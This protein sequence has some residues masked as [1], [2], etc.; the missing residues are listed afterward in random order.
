MAEAKLLDQMLERFLASPEEEQKRLAQEVAEASKSLIWVPNPGPQTEAYNCEADELLYGGEPS[1]GKSDLGIGLSLTEH[2]RSLVLRRTNAEAVKL[3]D[4]YEEIIGHTVGRNEQKGWKLPGRSIDIGGCQLEKDKQKRKGI[5]HDLKFFDELTDFTKTQYLFI[6]T[7]NRSTNPNQR[8]R[9]VATTNAPTNT[10][11]VWVIERWAAWLDPKHANPAKDGELRWYLTM[12]DDTEKEV[13]GPGPYNVPGETEPV[14][15]RSRTFIRS[16]LE[17]NPDM[18]QGGKGGYKTLLKSA[19]G[20]M[21]AL[22]RGDFQAALEDKPYQAI[23]TAWIR[24]AQARWTSQPPAGVPMCA[25][26]VDCSGGGKDPMMLAIRHDGWYDTL[27]EIPG[28]DIP[29]ERAGKHAAG[30]VVSYRRDKC[31]VIVDMGGGYG[32]ALYEKLKE[33]DIDAAMF[34]GANASMRRTDDHQYGF[35][36]MRTEAYWKFREALDP[37]QAGGSPIMLPNDLALLAELACPTFEEKNKVIALQP[38][39]KVCEV[40]GRSPDRADA[41]VMAWAYGARYMTHGK[42]WG[43]EHKMRDGGGRGNQYPVRMGRNQRR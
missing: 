9:I 35:S 37:S 19:G 3:F 21:R 20:E 40:L 26:G 27:V 8:C 29:I 23:P 41:V 17:D 28:S 15:A 30:I 36:N 38:K 39:E 1:G 16:R 6:I 12:P 10:A 33:N 34:K 4:R 2:K 42:L 11:G 25:I 32:T 7:W 18:V 43:A 31:G 22:A 5:P 13:D 14:Y 24:E